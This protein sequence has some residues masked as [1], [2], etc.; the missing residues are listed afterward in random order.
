MR[1]WCDTGISDRQGRRR[2]LGR[3]SPFSIVQSAENNYE[4]LIPETYLNISKVNTTVSFDYQTSLAS[5]LSL[6]LP[7]WV[8]FSS[9]ALNTHQP[10]SLSLVDYRCKSIRLYIFWLHIQPLA[11]MITQLPEHL[12]LALAP[13]P[14]TWIWSLLP[15]LDLRRAADIPFRRRGL[16]RLNSLI[17]KK[18]TRLSTYKKRHSPFPGSGSPRGRRPFRDSPVPSRTT[19]NPPWR[20]GGQSESTLRTSPPSPY[21]SNQIPSW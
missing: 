17:T 10:V 13:G 12:L 14:P 9:T 1:F 19:R 16:G 15:S 5:A 2:V 6:G 7:N 3:D 21:D 11:L 4:Y 8:H 20:P 18:E